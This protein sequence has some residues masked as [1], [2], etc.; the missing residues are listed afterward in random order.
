[1]VSSK[2]QVIVQEGQLR[3][4]ELIIIISPQVP[5]E[6]LEPVLDNISQFI[7][8]KGGVIEKMDRWGKKKLAY[9]LKH[10]IEG[11]FVLAT[12]KM[13]PASSRELE[14]QLRLTEEVLR[15]MLV[16]LG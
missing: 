1:M 16:R 10:F 13:N 4:Y 5:E 3:D 6:S 9:P 15:H 14:K 12:F 2:E 8:G 7:T 11:N